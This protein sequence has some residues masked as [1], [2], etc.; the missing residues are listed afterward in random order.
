M[1]RGLIGLHQWPATKLHSTSF[2]SQVFLAFRR[3]HRIRYAL[4]HDL[5]IKRGSLAQSNLDA[6]DSSVDN[7][8][9]VCLQS[10]TSLSTS[11][12]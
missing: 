2:K 1:M 11:L 10:S 12:P 8:A 5:E 4:N 9:L 3:R 7:L 6:S